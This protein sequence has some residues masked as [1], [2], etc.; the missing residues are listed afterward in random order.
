MIVNYIKLTKLVL[1][2]SILSIFYLWIHNAEGQK[3]INKINQNE[4][5]W[6]LDRYKYQ[7][8][9]GGTTMGLAVE[10]DE[11][12]SKYFLDL[13]DKK[14]DKKSRDRLAILSMVGEYRVSFEFIETFGSENNYKLDNPYQSWGTEMVIV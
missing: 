13:Q 8:I 12:T 3:I 14:L 7:D 1:F 2:F 10:L 4:I 5:N 9:R 11:N 6:L